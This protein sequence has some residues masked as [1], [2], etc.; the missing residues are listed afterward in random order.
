MDTQTQ[1]QIYLADQRGYTETDFQRS[2]HTFNAGTYFDE[3]RQPF[4]PLHALNDDTLRAG[5]A[6]TTVVP[7]DTHVILIPVTGGLEYQCAL[8]AGAS[9][10]G[11]VSEIFLEPGQAGC[12]W[13][14]VGTTYSISNPYET[15]A[16]SFL[17]LWLT[18]PSVSH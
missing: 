7:V 14:P 11:S 13:L 16:I 15:E 18:N 4:G 9:E 2:Y 3:S 10:A 12:F 17:Q 1:A 8:V 5:A 6:L